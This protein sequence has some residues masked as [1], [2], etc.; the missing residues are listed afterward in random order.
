MI[1]LDEM[2]VGGG[3]F[4]FSV[5]LF[6]AAS[7]IAI[8]A[9]GAVG[10]FR[11]R[12]PATIWLIPGLSLAILG[13]GST[14]YGM[15]LGGI[16]MSQATANTVPAMA[17]SAYAVGHYAEVLALIG[18]A[19]AFGV[20]GAAAAL[21]IARTERVIW[22]LL[23]AAIPVLSGTLGGFA[24]LA[25]TAISGSQWASVVGVCLFVVAG[26]AVM[27]AAS[28]ASSKSRKEAQRLAELRIGVAACALLGLVAWTLGWRIAHGISSVADPAQ[29][30]A[31]SSVSWAGLVGIAFLSCAA[32]GAVLPMARHA[33]T[34]RTAVGVAL[35]AVL[36]A[37]AGSARI[38][39][40]FSS[41][42]LAHDAFGGAIATEYYLGVVDLPAAADLAEK[43]GGISVLG[44]CFA[45]DGPSGWKAGPLFASLDPQQHID[46]MR[47]EDV[48]LSELDT[49][50]GC[51]SAAAPLDG[52][53]SKFEVPVLAI[54]A[55][56]LA[57][58]V[59]GQ[60]WFVEEG[61]LRLIVATQSLRQ[62]RARARKHAARA[63]TLHWELP[64]TG[65]GPAPPP[66]D[67]EPGD[68]NYE[69]AQVLLRDVVLLE[70][71]VPLVISE[72]RRAW[73]KDGEE[74][75]EQLRSALERAQHRNLV[76]VPRRNWTTGD[77]VRFCLS[78]ADVE[79][80]RCVIRPENTAR[81]SERTGL[82]LPW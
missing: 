82:A 11:V 41:S 59:T 72:G 70:G 27:G 61:D 49:Q 35:S 75:V 8:L 14:V 58:A 50:P 12:I 64:P 68:W 40:A 67:G 19:G 53:L 2:L 55:D 25:G 5:A 79:G 62:V 17:G 38:G 9:L 7:A 28:A 26:G 36:I 54:G 63:V 31:V 46:G 29:L 42:N 78:V 57:A 80:A 24:I 13:A 74:G 6:A 16:A 44:T 66:E 51:P 76:M 43:P 48:E 10:F 33:L 18:A 71:P 81:W 65:A 73:L 3:P 69:A 15:R 21:G 60:E 23:N 20:A 52:P 77:L 34:I 4:A 1:G 47:P 45:V 37:G 30:A 56:R 32:I 22:S 39:A